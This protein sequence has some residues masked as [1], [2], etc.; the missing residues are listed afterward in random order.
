MQASS[1][2]DAIV[3]DRFGIFR[4]G[5]LNVRVLVAGLRALASGEEPSTL[6]TLTSCSGKGTGEGGS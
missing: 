5:C 3:D 4:S 6:G 1:D 2:T